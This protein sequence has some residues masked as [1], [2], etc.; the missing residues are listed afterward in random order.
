MFNFMT[1]PTFTLNSRYVIFAEQ[2]LFLRFYA[3]MM[4]GSYYIPLVTRANRHTFIDY[5]DY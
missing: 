3:V 5:L 4:F 1:S 2:L